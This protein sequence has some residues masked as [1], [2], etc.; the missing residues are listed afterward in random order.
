MNLKAENL[1]PWAR[2]CPRLALASVYLALP[3]L[4]FGCVLYAFLGACRAFKEEWPESFSDVWP[5]TKD[6]TAEA[7]R[8]L[9]REVANRKKE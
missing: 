5:Y 8:R 9:R 4:F 1:R 6:W 7:K 3:L 2:R